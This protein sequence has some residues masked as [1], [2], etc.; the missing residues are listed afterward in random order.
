[1]GVMFSKLEYKHLLVHN[2]DGSKTLI[3]YNEAKNREIM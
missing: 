3:H 1:M 2:F